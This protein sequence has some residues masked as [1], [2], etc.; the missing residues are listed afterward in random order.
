MTLPRFYVLFMIGLS[1]LA[2]RSFGD[3]KKEAQASQRQ[4]D[5]ATPARKQNLPT[6]VSFNRSSQERDVKFQPERPELDELYLSTSSLERL[7]QEGYSYDTVC[8]N[9]RKRF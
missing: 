7:R 5:K 6:R 1:I 3:E 9:Y 2:S 4:V 8:R